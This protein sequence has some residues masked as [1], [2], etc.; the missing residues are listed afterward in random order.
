MSGIERINKTMKKTIILFF[1]ALIFFSVFTGGAVSADE[2]D[3]PTSGSCGENLI[4]ELKDNVLYISGTGD[5]DNYSWGIPYDD[6]RVFPPWLLGHYKEIKSLVISNGV[7]SI[8]NE[9]FSSIYTLESAEIPDSVGYIGKEAFRGCG[10]KNV[11]IPDSVR[12]IEEDAFAS[13]YLTNIYIPASVETIGEGAFGWCRNLTEISVDEKNTQYKSENGVLFNN[14]MSELIQYPAGKTDEEYNIPETVEYIKNGA[15]ESS[16][17]TDIHI[18]ESVEYIGEWAFYYCESL[19]NINIPDTVKT[20]EK[21]TFYDCSALTDIE[22]PDSVTSIGYSAFEICSSLESVI[23]PESVNS[24][25]VRAFWGCKSLTNVKIPDSLTSISDGA[26]GCCEALTD[27]IIPDKVKYIGDEAFWFCYGLTHITIPASVERL[28]V[29]FLMCNSLKEVTFLSETTELE[30]DIFHQC[31]ADL[32]IK[33]YAGSTAE[34][35]AGK[36]GFDFSVIVNKS[37]IEL[38]EGYTG[39]VS[40][41]AEQDGN[42]ELNPVIENEIADMTAYIAYFNEEG[43]MSGVEILQKED[44]GVY[45]FKIDGSNFKIMLWDEAS[46][47]INAITQ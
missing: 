15:F 30:Y 38:C 24:I 21:Y 39:T 27:I 9:A 25:G 26:F 42:A 14:D 23:I 16:R 43:G 44:D 35:Y 13:S 12:F 10:L 8:G 5:M 46:P 32:V 19:K 18:P 3:A 34:A 1:T 6:N 45:R 11:S 33:G 29:A 7:T 37:V 47:I 22:I 41:R 4:W 2:A 36:Y 28:R 17:L 31:P 40:F 20:I